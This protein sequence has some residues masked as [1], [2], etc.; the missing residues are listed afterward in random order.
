MQLLVACQHLYEMRDAVRARLG[1]LGCL[2]APQHG[3][4]IDA[5]QG[6]KESLGLYM[7]VQCCLKVW[8][9]GGIAWRVI[10]IGPAAVGLRSLHLSEAGSLHAALSDERECL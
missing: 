8:R 10:G 9:Y 7:G 4:A 2:H 6:F 1:P 3:I 5:V